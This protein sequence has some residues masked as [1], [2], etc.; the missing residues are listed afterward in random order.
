RLPNEFVLEW[1]CRWKEP[2][3]CVLL[4]EVTRRLLPLAGQSSEKGTAAAIERRRP[5]RRFA[6]EQH[7]LGCVDIENRAIDGKGGRVNRQRGWLGQAGAL[8]QHDGD[9]KIAQM[10]QMHGV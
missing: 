2:D 1:K 5:H 9:Y 4:R 6:L 7:R 10:Q 3:M 8:Q